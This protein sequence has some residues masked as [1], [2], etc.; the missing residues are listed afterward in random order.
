MPANLVRTTVV[1]VEPTTSDTNP[2]AAVADRT[3]KVILVEG[4]SLM[5]KMWN[6]IP[7]CEISRRRLK[8]M[9]AIGIFTSK[10]VS[11]LRTVGMDGL[12]IIFGV[13]RHSGQD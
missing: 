3:R 4:S 8:G 12:E 1:V 7:E 13:C 2:M 10:A 6:Y 5:R 9:N 11:I